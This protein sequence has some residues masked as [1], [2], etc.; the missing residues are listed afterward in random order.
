LGCFPLYPKL[1]GLGPDLSGVRTAHL[2]HFFNRPTSPSFPFLFARS[3]PPSQPILSKLAQCPVCLPPPDSDRVRLQRPCCARLPCLL[4]RL[5][6][7][8]LP[9]L[10][11]LVCCTIL[12]RKIPFPSSPR[13][14]RMRIGILSPNRIRFDTPNQI[15]TN[16]EDRVQGKLRSIWN[17]SSARLGGNTFINQRADIQFWKELSSKTLELDLA[18]CH[19]SLSRSE[20]RQPD[21]VHGW[22]KLPLSDLVSM[23]GNHWTELS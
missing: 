18:C 20:R 21:S 4:D 11:L 12:P 22:I 2:P 7:I 16:R 9:H 6:V 15:L 5:S 23:M 3:N 14:Q 17:P 8:M 1:G 13:Q 19:T 10:T